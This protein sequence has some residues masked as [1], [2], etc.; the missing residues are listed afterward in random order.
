MHSPTAPRGNWQSQPTGGAPN[1]AP[2]PKSYTFDPL[3]ADPFA[4]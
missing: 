3:R 2:P 4:S 1:A